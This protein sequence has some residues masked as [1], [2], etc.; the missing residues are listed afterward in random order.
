M[1]A[2]D[3]SALGGIYGH[4]W[5]ALVVPAGARRFRVDDPEL[6]QA[7]ADAG[8]T[9]VESGAEVD[10]TAVPARA[11]D[12]PLAIIE[13]AVDSR[14]GRLLLRALRRLV[15]SLVVRLR[16]RGARRSLAARY[17]TVETRMWDVRHTVS[18]TR[19]P[20]LHPRRRP[21]EWLPQRALV[22]GRSGD[23]APTLFD[24]AL[25]EASAQAGTELVPRW[26]SIRASTVVIAAG[27]AVMRLA[28]GPA[29]MQIAAQAAVLE[30]L[31]R[32]AP[33]EL[34][35]AR[36][37]WLLGHGRVSLAEWSL[38]R[39]LPG[40]RPPREL[41][42]SLRAE[43]VDFLIELR[44]IEGGSE[45]GRSL[46]ELAG[47]IAT[48]LEPDQAQLLKA[49][50]RRLEGELADLPRGFAHGDFFAG[51]LLAERDRL[52]AVLDWDAGG[53]GR[54]PLL[55]LLH[56]RR[57]LLRDGSDLW[58]AVL[59]NQLL[60]E[61]R[62]GGDEMVRRYC[63]ELGLERDSALLEALLWAYWLEHSA[64]QLRTH[65]HRRRDDA[66]IEANVRAVLR[67]A[68]G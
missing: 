53:R 12:A 59:V 54:L 67:V 24:V 10:I 47:A 6:A 29:Q 58:G 56:L 38:E 20:S 1:P 17:R 7:L 42:R 36:L 65:A 49:L 48:V 11:G 9:I 44:R 43:A 52:T 2:G 63:G 35:S 14:P 39:L 16:A 21:S 60:P 28:V 61:L 40:S 37:P 45:G 41:S 15:G 57:T 55:D 33:P 32:N 30:E 4:G 31:A 18:L 19:V 51:N 27:E 46:G 66:W 50:G 8:A 5:L 64:Y 25:R 62:A 23:Q 3:S 13:I 68:A 26:A 34:V 22:I